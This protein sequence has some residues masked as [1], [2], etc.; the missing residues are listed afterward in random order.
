MEKAPS[1]ESDLDDLFCVICQGVV[2]TRTTKV[3][4]NSSSSIPPLDFDVN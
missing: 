2:M 1:S 3:F 4:R